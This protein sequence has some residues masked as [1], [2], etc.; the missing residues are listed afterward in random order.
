MKMFTVKKGFVVSA[1]VVLLL[2]MNLSLFP[3]W[4]TSSLST[5]DESFKPF[6]EYIDKDHDAVFTARQKYLKEVCIKQGQ[7][8]P[9]SLVD[10]SFPG[11]TLV[12]TKHRILYC[13]IQ[14]V[15]SSFWKKTLATIGSQGKFTS[16]FKTGGKSDISPVLLY[17]DFQRE[18]KNNWYPR[19]LFMKNAV[20]LL[21]VRDPYT[22]LFS[23][24][25]DKLYHPNYLFWKTMGQPIERMVYHDEMPCGD[26]VS[27][28]DFIKYIINETH[29]G[30]TLDPHFTPIQKHCYPCKAKYDYI[31]KFENFKE[32]YHYIINKWNARFNLNISALE[33][34]SSSAI[35]IASKHINIS[36]TT[37]KQFASKC[38]IS[39][40]NF[41]AR[42]WRFL[43]ITGVLPKQI[44]LP[45]PNDENI[46]SI[47]KVQ[48]LDAVKV[49]LA[50]D[51]DWSGV[52]QQRHEALVQAYK[53]IESTDLQKLREILKPDC[54]YFNYEE[55]PE[56][57]TEN[58]TTTL[59]Y[60]DGIK[61]FFG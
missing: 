38:N 9:N 17:Q 15:G 43:Q 58:I 28:S 52:K 60:F 19:D 8:P 42:T 55:N 10:S 26:H 25:V 46:S 32:E 51:I 20:S 45:F 24:Y 39:P 27:F 49:V 53:S 23:A 34:E 30:T 29:K 54:Q 57:L 36:F 4:Y 40:Y 35:Y 44:E 13:P 61:N 3:E 11:S 21:V 16:R 47:T 5:F 41:L 6:R 59:N 1:A 33:L 56:Y 12:E 14:K 22:K 2:L 50:S 31:M 7:T 48:F 37:M 18:L